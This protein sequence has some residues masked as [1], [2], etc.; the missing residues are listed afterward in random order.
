MLSN[1]LHA[2]YTIQNRTVQRESLDLVVSGIFPSFVSLLEG[3]G[4][5]QEF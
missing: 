3:G 2:G 1:L 5:E 4:V